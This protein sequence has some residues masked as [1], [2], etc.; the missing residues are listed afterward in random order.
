M[1]AFMALAVALIAWLLAP[2]VR[3]ESVAVL[4]RQLL[5]DDDFKVRTQ[6]ALALGATGSR[7][8]VAPL[9]KGLDDASDAVRAA[10]ALGL[11]KLQ[12]GGRECLKG[13]DKRE[14]KSNV[15][16]MIAKALRLLDEAES[17]P[18]IDKSTKYYLAFGKTNDKSGRKDGEAPQRVRD[19][20][21]RSVASRA[22]YVVA[23]S[24][25]APGDAGK[26]LRKH[27]HVIGFFVVPT[28]IFERKPD[29]LTARLVLELSSYPDKEPMG[30]IMRAAG[31]KGTGDTGSE[32]E[33]QLI[34][35][36]CKEAM[37]EFHQLAAQL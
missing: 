36:L 35:R 5:G 10:A 16:K 11:G 9:C 1:K 13:R 29:S 22:G 21:A 25:E 15:K 30:R 27:P 20:L 6:A 14:Q 23:P 37:D 24:G 3:A 8:A 34:V 31:M 7:D 18:T 2:E 32:Q 12:K 28:L 17:G 26:R 4:A 33:N 19:G